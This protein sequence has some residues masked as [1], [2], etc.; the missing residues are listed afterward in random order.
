M[1]VPFI[2]YRPCPATAGFLLALLA[3]GVAAAGAQ[4][5]PFVLD[6]ITAGA[7][8]A[9]GLTPQHAAWCWGSNADGQLGN[10][11]VTAPCTAGGGSEPCS[12]KPVKV[13]SGVPFASIS[14]GH[15]FTCALSTSG[16]A[17]CWGANRFG[18]L[19]IGSQVPSARPAKVGIEGVAFQSI[20]AGDTHA[21]A[22]TMGGV[23]YCWGSN[24][25]GKLG[26]G[27]TSGGH[28]VPAL[29]GGH[30]AFRSVSAGFYHTCALTRDGVAWCW[31]RNE[32]GEL[33]NA[34]R[35]QS[36]VP[37]RVPAAAAFRL[38]HAAA[39]FDYTCGVDA[40]G[41]LR[42]W[43]AD[44]FGQ[45]G[46]DSLL[47]QCGAPP[48]PC[49]TKP[50]PVHAT[51]SFRTVSA[52]FSHTCALT[53]EGAV[54]CWGDNNAGQLGSGNS[55]DRN[56]VPTA[57]GGAQVY[58][59]LAAGKEFTCV[60]TAQGAAQCWGLNTLGQLGSGDLANHTTPVPVA[61]P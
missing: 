51:G 14:A 39:Q 25:G 34:P 5:P 1:S 12:T 2:R 21:C 56:S 6:S 8:H 30:V 26:A 27:G 59:A 46:V 9:C 16:V 36:S 15:G 52:E 24:A 4:A 47:E 45:L 23:A 44:C 37:S 48:M 54:L 19:G 61:Q 33:G 53:A 35:G 49:R 58:R 32:Q 3:A 43:G 17:Y 42:C 7:D 31:G 28:T 13:A 11:A 20:S 57:V 41:A 22:V 50:A 38:V 18:Q 60:I 29:V 55:G 40:S 10:P